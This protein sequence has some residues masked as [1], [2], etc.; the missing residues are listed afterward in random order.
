MPTKKRSLSDALGQSLP[1]RP[2]QRG[3]SFQLSSTNEQETATPVAEQTTVPEPESTSAQVHK[4]TEPA[5]VKRVSQGQ[6]L[7]VDLV[8]ELKRIAFE[9][10]RKLYEVMEEALEQYIERR[11]AASQEQSLEAAGRP[12][13]A[14]SDVRSGKNT[15]APPKGL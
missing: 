6:R 10:E 12:E 11:R 9:D 2:I 15:S 5:P 13:R 3:P 1:K 8:R 7:R 14:P 4:R